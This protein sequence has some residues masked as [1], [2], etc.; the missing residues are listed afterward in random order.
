MKAET[1]S[2]GAFP[3]WCWTGESFLDKIQI[4]KLQNAS[5]E[6]LIWK[7]GHEGEHV[8]IAQGDTPVGGDCYEVACAVPNDTWYF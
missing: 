6:Y 7:A 5:Y 1:R 3:C 8:V 2:S 4:D